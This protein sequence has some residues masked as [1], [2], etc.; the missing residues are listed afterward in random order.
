MLLS[1]LTAWPSACGS[2]PRS[3][4][5]RADV[6]LS[7]KA[8]EFRALE[9]CCTSLRGRWASRRSATARTPPNRHQVTNLSLPPAQ[10][11]GY[12]TQPGLGN[13]HQLFSDGARASSISA[14]SSTGSVAGFCH[15]GCQSRW[16]QP[17]ASRQSRRRLSV[18]ASPISQRDARI[19]TTIPTRAR[20][21]HP[22]TSRRR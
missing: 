22:S 2:W 16:K 19:V 1:D 8:D 4:T 21:S 13:G 17:S 18:M 6:R 14:P 9:Y 5:L 20:S 11:G 15:G 7:E 12:Q 3:P 10:A